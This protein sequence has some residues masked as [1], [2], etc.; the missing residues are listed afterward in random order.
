MCVCGDISCESV[1]ITHR[2]YKCY[3]LRVIHGTKRTLD[4]T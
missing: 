4:G 1:S 3:K 2:D